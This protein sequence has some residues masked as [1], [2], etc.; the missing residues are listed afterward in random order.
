M[1]VVE[2]DVAAQ[3]AD[4]WRLV[5]DLAQWAQLLPTMD[6]VDRLDEPGTVGVG[7]RFAVRQPGLPSAVYRVTEWHEGRGFTWEARFP[8]VRT[9]AAHAITPAG[10]GS[11]L[12]LSI[13]WQG[14]F[15][16]LVRR[17]YGKRAER[18]VTIEGDTF[19]RLATSA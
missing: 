1:L 12:A 16:G 13:E 4:V 2:R 6:A 14:A 15:A 10:D 18:L 19:A 3:P 7:S 9:I 5:S 11:H 8:G 17:L